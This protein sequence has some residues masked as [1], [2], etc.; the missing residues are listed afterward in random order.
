MSNAFISWLSLFT[1]RDPF[2]VTGKLAALW[3]DRVIIETPRDDTI[4]RSIKAAV[5]RGQLSS[6]IGAELAD[7]WKPIQQYLPDYDVELDS[8][9]GA[10]RQLWDTVVDIVYEAT[11]ADFP[12]HPEDGAFVHEVRM[13]SYGTM[14]AFVSWMALNAMHSCSFVTNER[15]ATVAERYFVRSENRSFEIF[16][17][18]SG[19]RIPDLTQLTWEKVWELRGHPQ[20]DAFRRK[21]EIASGK[22]TSLKE[23]AVAQAFEA[24]FRASLEEF[25]ELCRPAPCIALGKAVVSNL[26]LSI[27]INPA[28]LALGVK[29]VS[30]AVNRS[31]E[32]GWMF[33]GI[34][35]KSAAKR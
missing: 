18:F 16:R 6:R 17:H 26:P 7:H 10:G 2:G 32:Y 31:R 27:P 23:P 8:F 1:D 4:Q 3:F 30:D 5:S 34:D 12:D 14:R 21:L 15:E 24:D 19:L 25:A 22:D 13:A 29:E 28:S 11:K 9:D 35:L 33:F 20:L